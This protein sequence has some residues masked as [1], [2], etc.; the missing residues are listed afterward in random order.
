MP[1]FQRDTMR[2][3]RSTFMTDDIIL[4][5]GDI[6]A[7]RTTISDNPAI[8]IT[9]SASSSKIVLYENEWDD[10]LRATRRMDKIKGDW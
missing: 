2:S 9:N 8:I 10:F 6:T 3:Y 4:T 7:K 5:V 1:L